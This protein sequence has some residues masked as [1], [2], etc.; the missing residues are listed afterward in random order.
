MDAVRQVKG[1]LKLNPSDIEHLNY[2]LTDAEVVDQ[3]RHT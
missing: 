1:R 3:E 2:I